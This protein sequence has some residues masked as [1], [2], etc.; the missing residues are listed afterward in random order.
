VLTLRAQGEAH[1]RPKHNILDSEVTIGSFLWFNGL[2]RSKIKTLQIIAQ[3]ADRCRHRNFEMREWT[4]RD[5]RQ[6]ALG[7]THACLFGQL[8]T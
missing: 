3:G 7:A 8:S 5:A 6:E 1:T 2:R 4:G